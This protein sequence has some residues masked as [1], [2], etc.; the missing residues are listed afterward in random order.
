MASSW[1]TE[2]VGSPY[3][4]P[5]ARAML[6]GLLGGLVF[7]SASRS[8]PEDHPQIPRDYLQGRLRRTITLKAYKDL[9]LRLVRSIYPH[10]IAP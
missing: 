10:P 3:G 2:L 7:G 8:Y 4:G 1:S 5:M 6:S 9:C